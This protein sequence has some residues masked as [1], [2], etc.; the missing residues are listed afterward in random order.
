MWIAKTRKRVV[1]ASDARVGLMDELLRAIKLVKMY[2]WQQRSA[3]A[4]AALRAQETALARFG[5]VLK[6]F[7]IALVFLLPPLIALAIFGVHIIDTPLDSV[8]AFTTLSLFNTLRLPLVQLPKALRAFAEGSAAVTRLQAYLLAPE[9][10]PRVPAART[11]IVFQDA[12]FTYGGGG[13]GDAAVLRGVTLRIPKGTLV[14][15]AGPV[16][17]GKSSLIAGAILGEMRLVGGAASI[18]GTFAYVPQAPWCAHGTVRDNI[19]FG[20][21]WDEKRY[22]RVIWATALE[23]DLRLMDDGDLTL[24][25]ERGANLSG[26]QKQRIALARAAYS[27]A[28]TVLLDSPLSAVDQ[29]T[30]THIFQHCIRDLMLAAG[31]TVVLATHQVELFAR[32]ELLVVMANCAVAYAGPYSPA[33]VDAHFPHASSTPATDAEIITALQ[34]D[35]GGVG[36]APAG[37]PAAPSPFLGARASVGSPSPVLGGARV[38]AGTQD[39]ALAPA[40]ELLG[41]AALDA[42]A[43]SLNARGCVVHRAMSLRADM[44]T[45]L[46]D[47]DAPAA[48]DGDQPLA[49]ATATVLSRRLSRAPSVSLSAVFAGGG[50]TP[51]A[52]SRAPTPPREVRA[53]KARAPSAAGVGPSTDLVL[54]AYGAPPPKTTRPAA[55]VAAVNGYAALFWEARWPLVLL[56]LAIFVVTQVCRIYSDIFISSW[57]TRRYGH[58]DDEGWYLKVYAGYVGAFLALLLARGLFFYTIAERAASRM[59]NTMF[60]RI[61]RAPMSVFTITPLGSLLSTFS[62]DMDQVDEALQDNI[63]MATIYMCILGTTIGVVITSIPVFAAVAGALAVSFVYFFRLYMR[64]SRVLKDATGRAGAAVVTH[65][66]ETLQG[67]TV[68][69]AYGAVPRF[70]ADSTARLDAA[71]NAQ[72]NVDALQLW[73]SFRLDLIACLLVLGTCLLA[74]AVEPRLKAAT[75]GLAISNSFQ[76]LLFASVMVR[77]VA[78]I[79]SSIACVERVVAVGAIEQEADVPLTHDSC[80]RDGWP[81]RGEV[82]FNNVVMSYLPSL[83]A[84]LKGVTFNIRGGEKIG[85]AGRTG[86]GKSSLIMTLFRLAGLSEGAVRIDGVDVGTLNLGELRRRIAIIPQEPVMFKG[87]I[88]SNLDPFSERTDAALTVV[89]ER[90]MLGGLGLDQPVE[91]MGANFSLGQQQLLC[92][93]RAMLN[94]SKLLLL[95]EATAALVRVGGGGGGPAGARGKQQRR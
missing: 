70:A 68:V 75:A 37:G 93:A 76:I 65:V 4:V 32:A 83:P 26:G 56:S 61:L 19:L 80:P 24:I 53:P 33:V 95:D 49:S 23:P 62:A 48:Q 63:M 55:A 44:L 86:A 21:Q 59:H 7:N 64:T 22:R 2:N 18:G 46:R 84:V 11:E 30:S 14:M 10:A 94:P 79:D 20:R 60:A 38:R 69:L 90:C 87:T 35:G 8:L 52:G 12:S 50:G 28:D 82:D 91:A 57:V 74:I 34:L 54:A 6:S 15:V 36:E 9:R 67:L 42:A 1:A 77:T 13:A 16:G 88:R 41:D 73:L 43:N 40:G 3:D 78:D 51:A 27:G 85:V 29:F 71:A 47:T 89:L 5:G 45:A 81:S 17:S 39:G 31:A 66:S 72:F 25:G 58:A 92:L